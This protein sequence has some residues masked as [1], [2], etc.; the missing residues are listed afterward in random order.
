MI[1]VPTIVTTL[2][3]TIDISL[4]YNISEEEE[5]QVY[6]LFFDKW[7]NGVSVNN[8]G[9]ECSISMEYRINTYLNPYLAQFS[10]PPEQHII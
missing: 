3:S 7:N 8:V 1:S 2:D 6:K 10:P 9:S 5:K 4:F